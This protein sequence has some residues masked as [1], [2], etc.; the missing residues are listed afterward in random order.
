MALRGRLNLSLGKQNMNSDELAVIRTH[1]ANERTLLAYARTALAFL[2]T[3]A[4]LIHFFTSPVS[5]FAGWSFVVVGAFILGA[6][7]IRFI[8]LRH[9]IKKSFA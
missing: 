3:G 6:G 9:R 8:I 1:L 2:A 7:I 4:A 5:A